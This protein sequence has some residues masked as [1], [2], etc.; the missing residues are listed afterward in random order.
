[1]NQ[2]LA[3]FGIDLRG[4]D[5]AGRREISDVSILRM[6]VRALHELGPDRPCAIVLAQE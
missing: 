6:L 1:M 4:H 3:G 5:T 2:L